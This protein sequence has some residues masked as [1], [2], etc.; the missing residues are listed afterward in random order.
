MRQKLA[1]LLVSCAFEITVCDY[2]E[3]YD[4]DFLGAIPL[5]DPDLG[6]CDAILASFL[7]SLHSRL[8][9]RIIW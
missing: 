4:L 6:G 7:V 5:N 3:G 9:I 1:S 2:V 8:P